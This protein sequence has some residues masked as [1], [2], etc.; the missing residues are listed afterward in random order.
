[1]LEDEQ[2]P[3]VLD[4]AISALGHL[5]NLKDIPSEPRRMGPACGS[6]ATKLGETFLC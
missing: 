3:L 4:S 2:D 1:M 6:E 5:G